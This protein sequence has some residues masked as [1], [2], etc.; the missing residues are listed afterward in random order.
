MTVTEPAYYARFRCLAGDCPDSCCKDWAVDVDDDSEKYYK[1]LPGKLG[2]DLRKSLHREPE[3]GAYLELTQGRC[4]MWRTDGLCRIQA[5]LG[6]QALCQVCKTF[7][8]L[9]YDY[10]DFVERGLAL[11]CP[12]AARLILSDKDGAFVS[13]PGQAAG[14]GDYDP[15]LM[16]QLLLTRQ[17]LLDMTKDPA[18]TPAEVLAMVVVYS[19]FLDDHYHFGDPLPDFSPEN[20][21]STAKETA[22]APDWA[23]LFALYRALDVMT[24]AWQQRLDDGPRCSPWQPSDRALVRYYLQRYYLQA[25][26]DGDVAAY[27]TLVAAA[28]LMIHGTGLAAQLYSKEV[29]NDP[30]NV[31]ALLD[32]A[33][34]HVALEQETVLGMIWS[35][36][37]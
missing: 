8:R 21:V 22:G 25:A 20:M 24:P 30:D 17:Q 13:A 23:G 27:G 6:E 1:N 3:G 7:P 28:C 4:P 19:R 31:D 35:L 12:E 9:T 29:D 16:E 15:Q 2:A 36:I 14:T 5:E 34:E 32:A 11:S 18:W 37:P 33:H 10:G 26:Y